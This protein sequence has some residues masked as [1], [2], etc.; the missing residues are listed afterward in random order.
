MHLIR[1]L[2]VLLLVVVPAGMYAEQPRTPREEALAG[3]AARDAVLRRQAYAAL[4]EVGIA[5]DL[6]VLYAAL[7]DDDPAVRRIAEN[8]IWQIWGRSGDPQAD[9]LYRIGVRQ[10]REGLLRSALRTFSQLIEHN[11]AFTEAWNKRATVYFLLGQD[12]LSIADCD[13]VLKR[14]PQHFGALSGYGQL[15]LRR[16]Q[17][18]RA[19]DYFERALAAN[20]NMDG[21]RSTVEMLRRYLIER[22][23]R[24]I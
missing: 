24:F 11:P 21:V 20:P 14:N 19:L 7:Y 2:V 22:R 9:E 5:D 13:E 6:P 23:G 10:M 12:D 4:G 16:R 17:P 1:T 3:T 15:M 8:A 18:E